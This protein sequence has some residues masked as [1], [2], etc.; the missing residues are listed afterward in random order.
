MYEHV[1]HSQKL[2]KYRNIGPW[3]SRT[4]DLQNSKNAFRMR[5][6][7]IEGMAV[8]GGPLKGLV[9]GKIFDRLGRPLPTEPWFLEKTYTLWIY[10][11]PADLASQPS[12]ALSCSSLDIYLMHDVATI[13]SKIATANFLLVMTSAQN[14]S[15]ILESVYSIS[16]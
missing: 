4:G 13:H 5:F 7:K 12:K 6:P 11:S 2:S 3:Q 15:R 9:K 16:K 1:S 14:G 10:F 8:S